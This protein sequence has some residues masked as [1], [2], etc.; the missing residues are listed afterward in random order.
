MSIKLAI[1]LIILAILI[2][3]TLGTIWSNYK[4]YKDPTFLMFKPAAFIYSICA[5]L[6]GYRNGPK[7]YLLFTLP[8]VV[9]FIVVS[10]YFGLFFSTIYLVI[11]QAASLAIVL[12]MRALKLV[13]VVN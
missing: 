5:A 3:L 6:T 8:T 9:V 10:A 4:A 7:M 11:S 13:T 12:L 1:D 2:V